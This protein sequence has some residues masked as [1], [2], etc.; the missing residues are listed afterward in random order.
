MTKSFAQI[1]FPLFVR[2]VLASFRCARFFPVM[3]KLSRTSSGFGVCH[4]IR[5]SAFTK[6]IPRNRR[7]HHFYATKKCPREKS[8][9]AMLGGEASIRSGQFYV[10]F[11]P[12][13]VFE[14]SDCANLG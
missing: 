11:N 13:G 6:K 12:L 3:S 1:F 2:Y 9:D 8:L 10:C 5:M 7:R 4:V 14:N